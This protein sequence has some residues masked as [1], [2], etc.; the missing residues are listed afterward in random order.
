MRHIIIVEPGA[1]KDLIEI[2]KW[3][4]SQKP[5]LEDEFTGELKEFVELVRQNP[6]LFQIR[7]RALR[8]FVMRR[9]PYLVYY[10]IS[11]SKIHII[12]VLAAK[13]DQQNILVTR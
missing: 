12:A 13:Q 2:K 6:Y 1:Q 9:F 3:Y 4:R 5:G 8:A 7:F 10:F 11:K